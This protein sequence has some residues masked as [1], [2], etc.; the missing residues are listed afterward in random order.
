[1]T[2]RTLLTLIVGVFAGAIADRLVMG[3]A[4]HAQEPPA[5]INIGGESVFIGMRQDTALAKFAGKYELGRLDPDR[6]LIAKSEASGKK[7]ASLGILAF[8]N[9]TVE[10]ASRFWCDVYDETG[11][12]ELWNGL[13]G[14]LSQ[15][16]GPRRL[17]VEV[18]R[19]S[20]QKPGSQQHGITMH[21]GKKDIEIGK[22][23]LDNKNLTNFYVQETIF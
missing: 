4:V 8:G 21:F 2:T 17:P 12:G 19:F 18:E 5:T 16:V 1:M 3:T 20:H 14:A 13:D 11:A 7:V 9:G 23:H 6:V 15:Q 10:S 22:L